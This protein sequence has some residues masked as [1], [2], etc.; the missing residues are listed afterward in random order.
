M[1]NEEKELTILDMDFGEFVNPGG[2]F[3]EPE[4]PDKEDKKPTKKEDES[5]EDDP[6]DVNEVLSQTEKE[7]PGEKEKKKKDEESPASKTDSEESDDPFTLVLA[8]YQLEQGILSSF[9]EDE[10]RRVIE[11]EGETAGLSYLIQSEVENNTKAIS[12]ALDQYSQEYIELRKSGFSAEEAG[13]AVLQLEALEGIT[14]DDLREDDKEDLRRMIL[15]ENYK[16][17]TNFSEAKIDR[18]V[19]RSFDINVDV[20]DAIEALDGLKEAKKKELK[21]AKESQRLEQEKAQAAYNEQLQALNKHIDSLT[22]II[23]GK[24]INK[25]TKAKINEMLTKPVKQSE[26]GYAMTELWAKRAEN[27]IE[28]DTTLAY[29]YLSGVFDGKWDQI[30][31]TANTKLTDKLEKSLKEKG[32]TLLGG[33]STIKSESERT[34]ED[35]IG[36]MRHLLRD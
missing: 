36:P 16:A 7:E 18:L 35:M 10:L 30:M 14:E 13:G 12:S 34:R 3:L 19:K 23:P 20:D 33:R 25:Q 1:A 21:D 26:E 6:I 22:E 8:R 27:P 5:N 4:L 31:K 15:K 9:D 32:S 28:F 2:E 11:E 17:T 24:A 29:L